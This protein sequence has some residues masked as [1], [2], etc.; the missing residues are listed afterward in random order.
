MLEQGDGRNIYTMQAC[1]E[2]FAPGN[3]FRKV[4][5]ILTPTIGLFE[6]VYVYDE[7]IETLLQTQLVMYDAP[8]DPDVVG[9]Q[10]ICV[11]WRY[12]EFQDTTLGKA[13]PTG[14]FFSTSVIVPAESNGW[15]IDTSAN[16]TEVNRIQLF[17]KN[18]EGDFKDEVMVATGWDGEGNPLKYMAEHNQITF[19]DL[20]YDEIT[21][22]IGEIEYSMDP[23]NQFWIM[24]L[25]LLP[26]SD[27]PIVEIT[28]KFLTLGG[29]Q[30][31]LRRIPTVDWLYAQLPTVENEANLWF[32]LDN[33]V[34]EVL[35]EQ[36]GWD[37]ETYDSI[38]EW[39]YNNH[40]IQGQIESADVD[41]NGWADYDIY[42]GKAIEY[43]G[44]TTSWPGHALWGFCIHTYEDMGFHFR[45]IL[46]TTIPNIIITLHMTDT[47]TDGV[48]VVMSFSDEVYSPNWTGKNT[49]AKGRM[50]G[51]KYTCPIMDYTPGE[52]LLVTIPQTTDYNVLTLYIDRQVPPNKMDIM[53]ET[54]W[55]GG[56]NVWGYLYTNELFKL[57]DPN[58]P[59][60]DEFITGKMW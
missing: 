14:S 16:W 44:D 59:D 19:N 52:W 17:M 56:D 25:P 13:L 41:D 11:E 30:T 29:V 50:T 27:P 21:E 15:I 6:H 31:I 39:L 18:D 58:E 24:K 34:I 23:N 5:G 7:Y 32:F 40:L 51:L 35:K 53:E 43:T 42:T 8:T 2:K 12:P 54:G 9:D 46:T 37:G 45:I 60:N 38:W 10:T 20:I 1:D 26:E 33:D 49:I 36:T 3:Y 48:N 28:V 57:I 4:K 55:D 22:I 47:D